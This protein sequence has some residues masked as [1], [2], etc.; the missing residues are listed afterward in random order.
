M[1]A[2]VGFVPGNQGVSASTILGNRA[3]EAV[4]I[5]AHLVRRVPLR[6]AGQLVNRQQVLDGSGLVS[7]RQGIRGID[8]AC[9]NVLE[10]P[11]PEA[12][13]EGAISSRLLA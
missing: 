9:G 11:F 6:V 3:G 7:G 8:F 10:L 12:V 13:F 1:P 2:V 5:D 4:T